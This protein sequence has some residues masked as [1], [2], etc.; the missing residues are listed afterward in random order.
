M[1]APLKLTAFTFVL[2]TFFLTVTTVHAD[3][4]SAAAVGWSNLIVP[5]LGATLRGDSTRGLIE[6]TLEL[7]SYYGGTFHAKEGPFTIDGS[8]LVLSDRNVT[9][10][11]IGK[12]MQQFGLKLH[13]YNTF[14]NY[15]EAALDPSNADH[16]KLYQQPLYKGTWDETL[17]A[18]FKWKNL[19]SPWVYVPVLMSTAYLLVD[20]KNRKPYTTPATTPQEETLYGISEGVSFPLGSAFGEEV[21]F[22]GFIQR[23]M[24]LYTDSIILSIAAETLL[25]T[26]IHSPDLRPSA[27]AGGVLWGLS[28]NHFEGDLQPGIASHFWINFV[29][30]MLNFAQFRKSQGKTPIGVRLTVPFN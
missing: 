5:G 17:L 4:V 23:E 7:G 14:Y 18:P 21:L 24:R 15:R 2:L 10:P 16:E 22:R 3:H 20:Y 8:A 6:S 11:V 19:K 9:K 25:F 30:G 13:M 29:S 1:Q 27:A 12:M 26:L 28:V